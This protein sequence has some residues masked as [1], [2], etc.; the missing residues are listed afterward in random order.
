LTRHGEAMQ[1]P[2]TVP[3]G[4]LDFVSRDD[5]HAGIMTPHLRIEEC[6]EVILALVT[7]VPGFFR[8]PRSDCCPFDNTR[9][10]DARESGGS[11]AQAW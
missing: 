6:V 4:Q 8:R 1:G 5:V 9:N 10:R 11:R 7:V 2:A 3:V